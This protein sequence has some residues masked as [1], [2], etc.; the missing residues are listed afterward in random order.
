PDGGAQTDVPEMLQNL[1]ADRFQLKMHREMRDLPVYA[2]GVGAGGIKLSESVPAEFFAQRGPMNVAA[3]GNASGVA[4]D[5]G[6][7]STLTLTTTTLESKKLP[8]S[9]FA[10]MLTRFLDR[11]VV[12]QTNLTAGYDM[13]LALTPEDRMSMLIRSALSAGIVL[14]PQALAIL[15]V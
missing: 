13:S 12:D 7:G 2:L 15:D 3:G 11:P 6:Q 9:T 10:D 1:L 5:F 8:M 4:I 14:P